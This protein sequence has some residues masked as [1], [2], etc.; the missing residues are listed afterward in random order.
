MKNAKF[1]LS[2]VMGLAI[3]L[4]HS[5][6]ALCDWN[7]EDPAKWVQMPDLT[8]TG[9]DI[10][11]D[12][13]GEL[14]PR[15]IGD[16]FLCTETGP[17]TDVHLWG[18]W[19][20]DD[21]GRITAIH[22]SFYSDDPIGDEGSDPDN[23]YSK[24]DILLWDRW[25]DETQFVERSYY[26]L[27][28]GVYE[29]WWDPRAGAS[30]YIQNGDTEVWQI[31][32]DI[33]EE[34][35]EQ[36][37]TPDE[38]VIYWLVVEVKIDQ[39]IEG[40]S[41]GWKT[42]DRQDGHFMDDAVWMGFQWVELKYPEGHPYYPDSIDMAFVLTGREEEEPKH[43]LGDAPDS[44]NN[45]GF[46]M[47]AYPPGG[48]PGTPANF[49]TVYSGSPP[50]GP[51]H[52]DPRG[53]AYLGGWVTLENEADLFP[54]E[55]GITN[56]DPPVDMPD[57]D[58]ADD[59]IHFPLA[60]PHCTRT[61]FDFDVTVATAAGAD[62]YVNAWADW[63]R[64]GDWDDSLPCTDPIMAD[65]WIVKNQLLTFTSG[66][67]FTVTSDPFYAWH[68]A[69]GPEVIPFWLRI[70]LS[71]QP[72]DP[73]GGVQGYGGAG[74]VDGYDI[75][76]TEDFYV[77]EYDPG[78]GDL[79][80]GDAPEGGIAY[81][82]TG[83]IGD[84]PT[85][86]T[87][88]PSGWI[89]H[90]LCWA[91]F[92][93]G[94]DFEPD[95][96]AGTCPNCF[97]PY[98]QD[99][100]FNDGDAGLIIP[101]AFTIQGGAVVPCDSTVPSI[102]LGPICTT[103]VWG[104]NVD[105]FITNNMPVDGFVNVLMDWDQDGKWGGS[106]SCATAAAPEHVLV[107][108]PV[109]MGYS[110]PLSGL[111]PPP[112]LIGPNT[113]YVW[114]RFSVTERPVGHDW[115]GEGN[116][117]D[118]ETEDYLLEVID[119]QELDF[120]DAPDS[121]AAPLY[122]TLL[123]NGARH[124]IVPGINLGNLIDAELDGQPT[125]DADGDDLN[126]LPDED[127][128]VF[129]TKLVPGM[130]AKID[131][132]AS[133]A[134]NLNVWIDY[135]GDNSWAEAGDHVF[136]DQSIGMGTTTLGFTVP[137]TATPGIET[138]ARFRFTGPNILGI[139]Y[140]GYAR[141]GEVEDYKVKIDKPTLKWSQPPT[142]N[143]ASP[144]PDCFWG[145]DEESVYG[146]RQIVADDWLCETLHPVTDIHWWGSYQE[147]MEDIP[148]HNAPDGF[149][150]GIWTDVPAGV[151]QPW[152]HPGEM[153][154]EWRV[155]RA[156]VWE[157]PVGCDF[158]EDYMPFPD[159]CFRYDL[160]LPEDVWFWQENPDTIYWISISAVYDSIEPPEEFVWGWKTRRHYFN[161]DAVRIFDPTDPVPGMQ[162][163]A[164]E[165][166]LDNAGNSWDMAF[167]LTTIECMKPTHPDYAT[168]LSVGKPDCWCYE[169]NCRGDADGCLQFGVLHVYTIDKDIMVTG[170]GQPVLPPG[171]ICADFARDIQFG[172]LR[173]YTNDLAVLVSW[174]GQPVVT[175]CPSTDMNFWLT[176][177][178]P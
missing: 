43:D 166:I 28:D 22:L 24:P 174:Y 155:P 60:L 59:S 35:F 80:F 18:S 84:F 63:N 16:D 175:P 151:D 133:T 112:F 167:E 117:E 42:R 120:G 23:E 138:F 140:S 137:A 101:T 10:C 40:T 143:D 122:P 119:L 126:N 107:D 47:T 103:A 30:G 96:N 130:Y 74:P 146:W 135:N 51:I 29:G 89:Q 66:G 57:Q 131:V 169:Y 86:I 50:N 27:P 14:G 1:V 100:C 81:P 85:C 12:D 20:N 123:P 144:Y 157:R 67:I 161:D 83:V 71:G 91:Y 5:T 178:C 150:I 128:V 154:W 36:Q 134:G 17:I 21:K 115:N 3:L 164:G 8:E 168:W 26:K 41:F 31:N 49:P 141:E 78:Q 32:I 77:E 53:V 173:V 108:F 11:V 65:E 118:G 38:P 64:D 145:W 102:P 46:N 98:D 163:M 172:V 68:P 45:H 34:P 104:T 125:P 15:T 75:G 52:W 55:E 92:G 139:G 127:G 99:E 61:T 72:I 2:I 69:G 48:P 160:Q 25:F 19:L 109:P 177:Y 114:S 106:S 165:P 124:A 33:L 142:Y 121:S 149:H 94:S 93:P 159:T 4:G 171:A 148:P 95:G 170:Y 153:I 9:I 79:D 132:M 162:F 62:V 156:D 44:T 73:I 111:G 7:P 87:V 82:S 136:I 76:E 176:P 129:L 152:S 105:I 116:F 113:G 58:G 90:G 88:V 147:W 13:T 39:T 37:G 110:G 158:F 6:V 54:D 56:I 70:T 97:P